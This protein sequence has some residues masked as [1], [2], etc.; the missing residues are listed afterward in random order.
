K[1]FEAMVARAREAVRA[2][3]VF[4]VNLSHRLEAT[5]RLHPLALYAR[6]RDANPA[7]FGG[8]LASGPLPE[9]AEPFFV[10]SSSPERLFRLRGGTLEARPIAGT[11]PRGATPEEDARL[12]AELRASGKETAEH[13]MLVDLARNDLG[14]VARFG[15]VR[16]PRLLT[17]ESYRTVHHLVSV[18]EADLDDGRDAVDALVA[19]FPGGTITGAPKVRAMEVIEEVEPVRRGVYTGSLGWM[20]PDGDAD[21][22]IL[23]RTLFVRGGEVHLQVGAGIVEESE[24]AREHEETLAKAKGMLRALG[25]EGA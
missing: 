14:R 21:F 24:P 17:V 10:L 8:Y 2:G 16:V 20:S 6:L 25:V 1:E 23:I 19:L 5:T 4:Q 9:G 15:S 7:P 22:N 11:R 3:E 18:V 13:V 12:V